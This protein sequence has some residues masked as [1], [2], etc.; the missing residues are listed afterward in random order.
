MATI[1]SYPQVNAGPEDLLLGINITPDVGVDPPKTRSFPVS[2]IISL[3]TA[4]IPAFTPSDYDLDEFTNTGID[5]FAHISDIPAVPGLQEVLIS[6]NTVADGSVML[7]NSPVIL[8]NQSFVTYEGF[9]A[10]GRTAPG[11]KYF[12]IAL[13]PYHIGFADGST[14]EPSAFV[15]TILKASN[16][17]TGIQNIYELPSK[18]EGTY[19]L[20]TTED[21]PAIQPVSATETG[22]VNNT[23]L[24]ELGGTDKTINSVRVGRGNISDPAAE[25]TAFGYQALQSVTH[26]TGD[27]GYYNTAF[28]DEA[29]KSLTSGNSNDAFGDW[30]LRECTTGTYNTA[31]GG[32]ALQNLLGGL[33]NTAV[34][35][36][37]LRYNI[38][39]QRNT[40]VGGG[41]LTRN[42]GSNNTAIGYYAAGLA[43][44]SGNSNIAIGMQAGRDISTGGNNLLIENITNASITSGS[45]NIVLNPKQK[46]G[47]T[48]GSYN[49]I[50]GCWD[51][52][53]PS[54]MANNVI[55]G[56]GQGNIRFRTTDTGLTTVPGQ[57]NTL[58]VGDTT[59]KAVV[60]KEYISGVVKPYKVYTALLTRTG[61]TVD[62][63]IV[64]ENTLGTITFSYDQLG[65]YYINSSG[66][67]TSN[68]TTVFVGNNSFGLFGNTLGASRMDNNRVAIVQTT[69]SGTND[70]D[71]IEPVSI[72]I[73]VYN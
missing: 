7:F 70:E 10:Y 41:A 53:F 1:P 58:I 9:G 68:K 61:A 29:L 45:F 49:T 38:S 60:T 67:F 69:T 15:G 36:S 37:A 2:S 52:A 26:T 66:L 50:I 3:A 35:S 33:A 64:L 32:G 30:A 28:G 62:P 23:S 57:T 18:P 44:S 72:E 59:G 65:I 46:S 5:P 27:T 21:V 8:E 63:P 22:V 34:G 54:A 39:G 19:T 14:T 47:V 56:D 12:G 4:A 20:A 73:R 31:V 25:N 11:E 40:A 16:Y 71:W 42:T 48:T 6:N 24:Q 43:T 17:D 13:T 51:G 55:I